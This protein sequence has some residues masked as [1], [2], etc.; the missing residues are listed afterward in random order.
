MVN[1]ASA[2]LKV[3][4]TT[5]ALVRF[6]TEAWACP[7]EGCHLETKERSERVKV[8]SGGPYTDS[9]SN[10]WPSKGRPETVATVATVATAVARIVT[11]ATVARIGALL[12]STA[13]VL[14]GAM[15]YRQQSR[16]IVKES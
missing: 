13:T 4:T 3:M 12:E 1:I 9:V 7:M 15:C 8:A 16:S 6:S 2:L 5:L 10:Y 14:L 11:V